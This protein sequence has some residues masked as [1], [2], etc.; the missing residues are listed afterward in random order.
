[1]T[2]KDIQT[3]FQAAVMAGGQPEGAD[4]LVSI[5]DSARTNRATLFG[6]YVNAY[7]LRLFEFMTID[8]P[9]LRELLGEEAFDALIEAYVV[10]EP[11]RFRN[12]RWFSTRLPDFMEASADWRTNA[13]A[14]SLAR[15][16]RA[17]TDA[18]DAP[19]AEPL[20]LESL[21]GVAPERWPR[22]AF[23]FHP[24][25]ILLDLAA[26][27]VE[28]LD[29]V[30]EEE[31]IPPVQ[32]EEA[33]AVAVWRADNDSVYRQLE[34]DE[35]LAL[36]EARAGHRFGDICQLVAF[37]DESQS[38]TERLAQF[39]TSWFADGLVVGFRESAEDQSSNT[40]SS[41]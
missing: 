20:A 30:N 41:A 34:P 36:N 14:L 23:I 40:P 22:L 17:L 7:R 18:F 6:V 21:G 13:R 25:L 27:V 15:L 38:A 32:N 35:F 5:K 2:L 39:L 3:K 37:Q 28:A 31:P 1:V 29:A 8:Y 16:E 19:D 11:S 26:G 12:A 4:I 24:S 33:N 10:A 9:A